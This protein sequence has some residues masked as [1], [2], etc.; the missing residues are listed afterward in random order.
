[1]AQE[2][3]MRVIRQASDDAREMAMRVGWAG[4][5]NH[6]LT[7]ITAIS[8]QVI[9]DPGLNQ[10]L[11]QIKGQAETVWRTILEILKRLKETVK[12]PNALLDQLQIIFRDESEFQSVLVLLTSNLFSFK[13]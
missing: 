13:L 8:F 12:A 2:Q 10:N 1:M 3:S 5:L 11:D 4:F 7:L 6:F 9:H